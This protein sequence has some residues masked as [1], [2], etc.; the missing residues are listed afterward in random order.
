MRSMN[1]IGECAV[2]AKEEIVGKDMKRITVRTGGGPQTGEA[3]I[4]P[5]S[6][7]TMLTLELARRLGVDPRKAVRP[8]TILVGGEKLVG[9]RIPVIIKVGGRDAC[10]DGFVPC[11]R[12]KNAKEEDFELEACVIGADF[13][14]AVERKPKGV[15]MIGLGGSTFRKIRPATPEEEEMLRNVPLP[16]EE[17]QSRKDPR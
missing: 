11:K 17:Q 2:A 3:I 6:P 1:G 8:G 12:R 15:P 4:D 13:F 5:A 14:E 10:V 16:C 7:T 9:F